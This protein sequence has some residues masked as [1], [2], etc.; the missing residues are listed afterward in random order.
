MICR[1]ENIM[2]FVLT[3]PDMELFDDLPEGK[4]LFIQLVRQAAINAMPAGKHF[5]FER[6]PRLNIMHQTGNGNIQYEGKTLCGK[7]TTC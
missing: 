4:H 6:D 3:K 5:L 2:R 1:R 7:P